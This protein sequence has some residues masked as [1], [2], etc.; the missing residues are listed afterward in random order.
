MGEEIELLDDEDCDSLEELGSDFSEP[1]Q[2]HFPH[3]SPVLKS[4]T[5]KPKN[6]TS[7]QTPK[8][9]TNDAISAVPIHATEDLSALAFDEDLEL[10]NT[11]DEE[12]IDVRVP[13]I[14]EDSVV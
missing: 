3:N 4:N 1:R 8:S 7:Q 13:E 5:S 6:T 2:Q 12:S 10:E 14:V 11:K 9:H